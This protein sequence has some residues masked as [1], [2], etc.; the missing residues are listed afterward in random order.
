[1]QTIIDH[2]DFDRYSLISGLA[3]LIKLV[4][5]IARDK[6]LMAKFHLRFQIFKG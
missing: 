6:E 3:A 4:R 5:Q 1:M 2:S